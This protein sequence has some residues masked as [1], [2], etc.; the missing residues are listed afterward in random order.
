MSYTY[1]EIHVVAM[2][3]TYIQIGADA[4]ILSEINDYFTFEV[5]GAKFMPSF[6]YGAWDGK[7]RM[8]SHVNQTLY[9]GLYSQLIQFATERDYKVIEYDSIYPKDV[10]KFDK[11]KDFMKGL[12]IHAGGNKI[13]PHYYQETAIDH[14]L[15]NPRSTI[16]SPTSSGKSLIIYSLVRWHLQNNRRI[17]II[18]PTIN[19]VMQMYSDFK[20]YSSEIEWDTNEHCHKI[21]SGQEKDSIK[22]VIIST[23]QSMQHNKA[24]HFKKYD[25][26]IVDEVH[27]A[28]SDQITK[29]MD[30]SINAFYR[31]GFTGTLQDAKIH[32]L[33]IIGLFGPA[34]KIIGTKTLMDEGFVAKLSIKV[35]M[36]HYSD[37]CKKELRGLTVAAKK[38]KGNGYAAEMDFIVNHQRRMDTVINLTTVLQG[39][40]LVLFQ[41]VE[42]HGKVI[43]EKLLQNSEKRVYYISG[44]TNPDERERIRCEMETRNDI[45]LVASLGTF[46]TGVSVKNIHN[47]V[48][49]SPSKSKI[50]VLQSIGRG[51]RIS[52]TK[53][54]VTLYDIVDN[55]TYKARKHEYQNYTLK[56]FWERWKIYRE[57]KFRVRV[58]E[59]S[60]NG[61]KSKK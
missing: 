31:Y 30:R 25:V 47:I 32:K 27:G 41:Y 13:T 58:Y 8:Y 5:P 44:E 3:A 28:K 43:Y 56:H 16:V 38:S 21:Y 37:E 34:K 53:D 36:L 42:K 9:L 20:D 17:L 19:L 23:W 1:G 2:N 11:M 26:V 6:K 46:S 48:Q 12:D 50:K 57:E 52:K 59:R 51:L 15:N 22:P 35:I 33:V 54:S 61:T 18:V 55:I 14:A 4:S 39:N 45:I 7:K 29:I 49:A 40:T 60:L 24:D 10:V